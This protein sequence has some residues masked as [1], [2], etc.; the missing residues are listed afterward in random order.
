VRT[1]PAVRELYQR[2]KDQGL[3]VI[4]LHSPEFDYEKNLTDVKNA[5]AKLNVPYPVALDNDF[6]TWNAFRN[7]YWPSLYFIDKRGVIRLNHI[8]ELHQDTNEW[9]KATQLIEA[10]LKE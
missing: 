2:Y 7:R 8:G 10:M 4:G 5:I 1:I 9:T 6:A 3:I